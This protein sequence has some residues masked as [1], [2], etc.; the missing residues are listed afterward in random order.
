MGERNEKHTKLL[1]TFYICFVFIYHFNYLKYNLSS[2]ISPKWRLMKAPKFENFRTISSG[3]IN[4]I[5]LYLW[6]LVPMV[7]SWISPI[8]YIYINIFVY[9]I[10]MYLIIYFTIEG[11]WCGPLSLVESR[12]VKH[13]KLTHDLVKPTQFD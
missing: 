13:V 6:Q 11:K 10:I 7:S 12:V 2:I 9:M 8:I 1:T 4:S 3:M 5:E